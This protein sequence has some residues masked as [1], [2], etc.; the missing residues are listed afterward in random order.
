MVSALLRKAQ[1]MS[2]DARRRQ[3]GQRSREFR[4]FDQFIRTGPAAVPIALSLR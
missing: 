1:V 2:G 3:F 4:D